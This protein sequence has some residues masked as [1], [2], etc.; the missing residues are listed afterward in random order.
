MKVWLEVEKVN[1]VLVFKW[2]IELSGYFISS[3]ISSISSIIG[4]L[5]SSTSTL[6]LVLD[7]FAWGLVFGNLSTGFIVIKA[8]AGFGFDSVLLIFRSSEGLTCVG[9]ESVPVL[10]TSEP[11]IGLIV[12]ALIQRK[13]K[14]FKNNIILNSLLKL[15]LIWI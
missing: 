13:I 6:G 15:Y 11:I 4:K 8:L 5:T 14:K 7:F 1:G 9:F 12:E 10:L 3:S 2:K